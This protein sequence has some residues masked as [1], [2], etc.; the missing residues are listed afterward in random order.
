[1]AA[2]VLFCSSAA[3][4]TVAAAVAHI[5][6]GN[7]VVGNTAAA[8]AVLRA[9]AKMNSAWNWPQIGGC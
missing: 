4:R 6:V 3:D 7:I 1:M 2:I 5:A 8:A 9:I